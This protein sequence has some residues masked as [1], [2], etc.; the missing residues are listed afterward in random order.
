MNNIASSTTLWQLLGKTDIVIP[1][2]QRDYA[3]GRSGYENLREKFLS[4]IFDALDQKQQLK[5]DFVYG[6]SD[7]SGRFNP[8]DGQQR[9]TTLWLIHWYLAF[10]LGK[11]LDESVVQR[12]LHFSYETRSSS[13][14]FCHLIVRRGGELRQMDHENIADTIIRQT[15][16]PSV[17]R[18]DPTVQA[19]LRMLSGETNGKIDGIE[20]LFANLSTEKLL[21]YWNSL[22][23]PAATCPLVFYQ[24]DLENLGQSDDLYV[25]MNGRGKPLSD[26]ENFKAD[27]V[28]YMA[29]N[30]WSRLLDPTDG[31]PILLDTKWTDFFWNYRHESIDLDDVLFGF[32]NRYFLVRLMVSV[33]E[34]KVEDKDLGSAP[35]DKT[36]KFLYSFTEDQ[37]KRESYNQNGF[38][39]YQSLFE[40]IGGFSSLYDLRI[41]L[42]NISTFARSQLT[43]CVKYMYDDS[44]SFEFVY[45]SGKD[46]LYKQTIPETIAFWAVCR[47]FLS[48][49]T[50]CTPQNLRRWMRIVWNVCN[51]HVID[52]TKSVPEIRSKS[53]LRSSIIALDKSFKSTWDVYNTDYFEDYP[54]SVAESEQHVMQHILEEQEKIRKIVSGLYDGT[55]SYL[56]GRTWEDIIEELEH[57][58][59][60][61]GTIRALIYDDRGCAN[62]SFFDTK[63][64]HLYWYLNNNSSLN[65]VAFRNYLLQDFSIVQHYYWFPK[66]NKRDA[67][68]RLILAYQKKNTHN[69][70]LASPMDAAQL[71]E[72]AV[73]VGSYACKSIIQ[74]NL[75]EEST[76][77]SGMYLAY[78]WTHEHY[79]YIH[80]Q[81]S[82]PYIIFNESRDR[83]LNDTIKLGLITLKDPIV[84]KNC[85][86]FDARDVLFYYQGE[87]YNWHAR[88]TLYKQS[89]H[90]FQLKQPTSLSSFI[91]SMIIFRLLS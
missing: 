10:K 36:F 39:V 8:L 12:L 79:V 48:P 7:F 91:N 51:Y 63:Y 44:E 30:G 24:L 27:L 38:G 65:S 23:L 64:S 81:T 13:T 58:S 19:M 50:F 32:I 43:D 72:A 71:S 28:K 57:L 68:W 69:W 4:S 16:I 20:E 67:F 73:P 14:Q 62:W 84:R 22:M 80:H 45:T 77:D 42:N 21:C 76:H 6:S 17:W 82:W 31:I 49:L 66:G 59:I 1:I 3:Q 47:F 41:I 86:L 18:Q 52:N 9:L 90:E 25:K 74:R 2:L 60:F 55:L 40:V 78:S 29:D 26:Y 33:P 53:A 15:W 11:L 87:L 85:G 46:N 83:V 34:L 88:G 70:L 37:D 56:Q 75:L 35:L 61:E 5:L 54:Q 89:H